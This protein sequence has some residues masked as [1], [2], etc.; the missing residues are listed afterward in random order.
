M[1]AVRPRVTTFFAGWTSPLAGCIRK[2]VKSE[3]EALLAQL[4]KK[5]FLGSFYCTVVDAL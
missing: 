4:V 5:S 3:R 1:Q 2:V